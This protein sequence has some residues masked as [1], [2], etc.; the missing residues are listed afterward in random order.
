[1]RKHT[2]KIQMDDKFRL[3]IGSFLSKEEKEHLSSFRISRQA[4]GKIILDPL[5]EIP[6]SDHWIYKN[7]EA[8]ASIMRGIED[9]N[10]G[11]VFDLGIDFTQFLTEEEKNA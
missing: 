4:D 7:P 1:M 2:N 3:C 5:V 10:A 8:L 9:V 11:R 6:A